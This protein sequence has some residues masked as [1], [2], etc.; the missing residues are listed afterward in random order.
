[1]TEKE[2]SVRKGREWNGKNGESLMHAYKYIR[3]LDLK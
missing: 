2:M 1:M 3:N